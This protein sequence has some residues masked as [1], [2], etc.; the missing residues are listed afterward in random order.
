MLLGAAADDNLVVAVLLVVGAIIFC[1][2]LASRVRPKQTMYCPS[3]GTR[4]RPK[5]KYQGS[6]VLSVVLFLLIFPAWIA[7]EI[8]RSAS[9]KWICPA[10]GKAGMVPADTPLANRVT[11][12][13]PP[14]AQPLRAFPVVPIAGGPGRFRVIGV[15]RESRMDTTWHCQAESEANARVKA[16]L[17]GIIVTAVERE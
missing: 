4:E 16:E 10:C 17:E 5:S 7:Y 1:A 12:Q 11:S 2:F 8:W 3:C 13:E 9:A 15:D 14:P 6:D